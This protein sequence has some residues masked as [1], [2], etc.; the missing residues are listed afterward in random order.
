[1]TV[2]RVATPA[3]A[4]AVLAVYAPHI[5]ESATSF[6]AAP[7][8][9]AE[10]RERI[11]ARLR[12]HPWLVAEDADGVCGYAC[13]S[14]FRERA[15]YQWTC[16]SSVYLA[17]RARGRGVGARLMRALLAVLAAQGYRRV[18]AG[19]TL[20]NPASAR[21]HESLG[22]RPVGVFHGVGHKL[23][24]AWDV[25]FWELELPHAA[26]APDAAPQ[27]FAALPADARE[28]LLRE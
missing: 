9:E 3:D 25:G 17:A 21:L 8:A 7:P 28:R 10:M 23:G 16:E 6:E 11:A 12:T 2:L 18:V 19:A 13:A 1:M 4:A 27:P 26:A 24:R 22:F 5:V 15:A 20:P 14:V